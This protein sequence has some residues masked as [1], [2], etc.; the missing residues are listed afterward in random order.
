LLIR[1]WLATEVEE[2]GERF[3]TVKGVPQG[4]PISPLLANLYLDQLD[5][6]LL[7]E[8]LRLVRFA[9]DFLV[10]CASRNQAQDALELTE[11]ILHSL[12]LRLNAQKTRIVDF[13]TGF[14]FL[15]VRFIRSL[16]LESSVPDNA[17]SLAPQKVFPQ[18]VREESWDASPPEPPETDAS[19]PADTDAVPLTAACGEETLREIDPR[20]RT[21]YLLDHCH[22]LGKESE[23]F[24]IRRNGRLIQEIP[25]I[26]VDQVMICGNSQITTQAMHFCLHKHIPIHLLS[27]LGR[28][29]GMISSFDTAPVVLHRDQFATAGEP[30]FLPCVGKGICPWKIGEHTSGAPP[31]G[32]T[33]GSPSPAKGRGSTQGACRRVANSGNT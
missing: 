14:R 9:D 2:D 33:Q 6:A 21:L 30:H 16:V 31:P 15:G 32:P 8:H 17:P 20:L 13:K 10:L 25:A 27:A 19:E 22:V 28:Y 26:K 11:D 7:D 5:E 23:R 1:L 12:R 29:Q 18:R 3:A 4:S 24:V